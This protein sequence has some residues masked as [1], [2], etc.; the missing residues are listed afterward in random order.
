MFR[1]D[2]RARDCADEHAADDTDD[3]TDGRRR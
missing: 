3:Y 1:V 2:E